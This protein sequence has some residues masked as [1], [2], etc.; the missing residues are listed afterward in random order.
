M[1]RVAVIGCGYVGLATAVTLT[2]LEHHVVCAEINQERL[3]MLQ[4]ATSPILEDG[5]E[6][7]LR[8]GLDRGNL[9]F[10]ASATE[11]VRDA[12][13]VFLACRPL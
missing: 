12:E 6:D 5:L 10:V 1:S 11:A 3:A 4:E 2:H 8:L 7:L 9:E 13:F